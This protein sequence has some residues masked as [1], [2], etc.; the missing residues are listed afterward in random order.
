MFFFL[1]FIFNPYWCLFT[2]LVAYSIANYIDLQTTFPS[3]ALSMESPF[4]SLIEEQQSSGK[5]FKNFPD[6]IITSH[7]SGGRRFPSLHQKTTELLKCSKVSPQHSKNW[8]TSH[9]EQ[10]GMKYVTNL[11]FLMHSFDSCLT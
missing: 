6:K 11:F 4:K 10:T 5:V 1:N 3:Q 9:S 2:F 7:P 8:S